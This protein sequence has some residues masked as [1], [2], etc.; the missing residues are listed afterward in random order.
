MFKVYSIK[1]IYK[2]LNYQPLILHPLLKHGKMIPFSVMN[3][4]LKTLGEIVL[5]TVMVV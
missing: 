5:M 3:F 2:N 4:Y 1:L